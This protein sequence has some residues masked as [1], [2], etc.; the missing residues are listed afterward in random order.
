MLLVLGFVGFL[1]PQATQL[2]GQTYLQSIGVPSFTTQLPVENGF[3]NAANGDLHL[4]IP[5]GTFPRRGGGQETI[6]LVYDSNI[7]WN[8][9]YYGAWQPHN[10]NNDGLGG[11]GSGSG[12]IEADYHTAG[13]WRVVSSKHVGYTDAGYSDDGYGDTILSPWVYVEPN[14]TVHAFNITT[15]VSYGGYS[16]SEAGYAVDGTGYYLS[17]TGVGANFVYAPDGSQVTDPYSGNIAT[18]TNGNQ[19]PITPNNDWGNPI[20]TLNRTL[21]TSTE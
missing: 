5:M 10:V 20:D 15:E 3:I 2:R 16:Y 1:G 19:Y 21:V 4:E 11:N 7:W 17:A 18:D 12:T 9:P 14:G 6:S 8:D 13:G